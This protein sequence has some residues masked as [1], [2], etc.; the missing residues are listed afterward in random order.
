M[1]LLITTHFTFTSTVFSPHIIFHQVRRVPEPST[2]QGCRSV[3]ALSLDYIWLEEKSKSTSLA[4]KSN[5]TAR[6]GEPSL[7]HN[8]EIHP[9]TAPMSPLSAL[10][11]F[12]PVRLSPPAPCP[13]VSNCPVCPVCQPPKLSTQATRVAEGM[14]GLSLYANILSAR[15][16][17]TTGPRCS[18][19]PMTA[20]KAQCKARMNTDRPDYHYILGSKPIALRQSSHYQREAHLIQLF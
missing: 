7:R 17:S 14:Q 2:V 16:G 9:L 6:L 3:L 15:Q 1:K 19:Q 12:S 4:H 20:G 10:F 18:S 11:S 8:R 13:G 5:Q